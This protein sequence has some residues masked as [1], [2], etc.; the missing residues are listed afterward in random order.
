MFNSHLSSDEIDR[1]ASVEIVI[2]T[3]EF[4]SLRIWKLLCNLNSVNLKLGKSFNS[5]YNKCFALISSI[6]N[7]PAA[8]PK[9]YRENADKFI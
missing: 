8:N 6:W 2:V 5:Q 4:S 7:L 1:G 9:K 3:L